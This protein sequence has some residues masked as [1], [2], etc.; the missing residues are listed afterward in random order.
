MMAINLVYVFIILAWKR[1]HFS[2][3]KE[4]TIKREWRK[5]N[6]TKGLP[7]HTPSSNSHLPKLHLNSIPHKHPASP[8][9]RV[10]SFWMWRITSSTCAV[11]FGLSP[12]NFAVVGSN[13]IRR[14]LCR[15]T[16]PFFCPRTIS[17]N[18]SV[19]S[20]MFISTFWNLFTMIFDN[21]LILFK[22]EITG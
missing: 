21:L 20:L 2:G 19:N 13:V 5:W 16:S 6:K 10:T 18:L 15:K 12:F 17:Q 4:V 22:T 8:T 14:F 9:S 1:V 11:P 7:I 3:M